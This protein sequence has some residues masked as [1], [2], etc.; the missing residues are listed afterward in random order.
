MEKRQKTKELRALL[1]FETQLKHWKELSREEREFLQTEL[2]ASYGDYVEFRHQDRSK[3]SARLGAWNEEK[4]EDIEDLSGT[5]DKYNSAVRDAEDRRLESA[6]IDSLRRVRIESTYSREKK[7]AA[8][9]E[10][11][12]DDAEEGLD[13]LEATEKGIQRQE[14][15]FISS[16]NKAYS[17]RKRYGARQDRIDALAEADRQGYQPQLELK[18]VSLWFSEDTERTQVFSI[19]TDFWLLNCRQKGLAANSK[20]FSIKVFDAKTWMPFTQIT[21]VDFLHMRTLVLR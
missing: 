20:G 6:I 2:N 5:L 15:D 18:R 1:L 17:A 14:R 13:K 16:E 21:D 9:E 11:F 12:I 4:S 7:A 8:E 3:I 10:E 19:D